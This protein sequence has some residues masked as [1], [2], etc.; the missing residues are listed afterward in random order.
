MLYGLVATASTMAEDLPRFFS[1]YQAIVDEIF[2]IL[3]VA[4]PY[5]EPEFKAAALDALKARIGGGFDSL[6]IAPPESYLVSSGME[7]IVVG[8]EAGRM[9]AGADG[10]EFLSTNDRPPARLF[11]IPRVILPT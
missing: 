10:I 9:L 6:K 3:A 1:L 7:A 2:I 4:R 5:G 8:L 11:R